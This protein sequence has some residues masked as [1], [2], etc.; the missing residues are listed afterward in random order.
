MALLTSL[1][2]GSLVFRSTNQTLPDLSPPVEDCRRAVWTPHAGFHTSG[3]PFAWDEDLGHHHCTAS[4]S[5]KFEFDW[6]LDC[7]ND[8]RKGEKTSSMTE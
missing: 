7:Y 4:L 8:T 3:H 1:G 2:A 5:N 6:A